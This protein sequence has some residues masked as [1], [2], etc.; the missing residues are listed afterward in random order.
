M[1]RDLTKRVYTKV[2][3]DQSAAYLHHVS[4]S[5]IQ[6]PSDFDMAKDKN[7]DR[8]GKI[9]YVKQKLSSEIIIHYQNAIGKSMSPSPKKTF[10][11]P[12]FAGVRKR[13]S[14]LPIQLSDIPDKNIFSIIQEDSMHISSF[15]RTDDKA[16]KIFTDLNDFWI[17]KDPNL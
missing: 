10:S 12:G 5:D 3:F 2:Y 15:S 6:L 14:E 8:A 4:D 13:E 7:L 1:A 9:N 11:V 16:R 17:L